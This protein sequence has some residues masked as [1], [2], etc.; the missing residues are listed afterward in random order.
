M[1]M[2]KGRKRKRGKE[3]ESKGEIEGA[4]GEEREIG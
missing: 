1:R 2:K 4:R 3:R